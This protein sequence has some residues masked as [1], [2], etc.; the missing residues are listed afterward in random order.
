[1]LHYNNVTIQNFKFYNCFIT[2]M[3][4]CENVTDFQL[5]H[6][7]LYNVNFLCAPKLFLAPNL[8]HLHLQFDQ[9]DTNEIYKKIIFCLSFFQFHIKNGYI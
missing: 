7:K 5:L 8:F 6:C 1:M 2:K 3:L 9:K 4:Q